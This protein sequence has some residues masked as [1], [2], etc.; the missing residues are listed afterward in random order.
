MYSSVLRNYY[1]ATPLFFLLDYYVHIRL[2]V[3][4][5]GA[6][7]Y[8]YYLYYLLCFVAGFVLFKHALLGALFSLL[9]SSI[10]LLLL[11]LTVFVPVVKLKQWQEQAI[12]YHFGVVELLHFMLV[13]AILLIGF[14]HNPLLRK[15]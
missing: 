15:R 14:Y 7:A 2:R 6:P 4:L 8:Y 3:A 11:L 10:N 5:P 9:E 12:T 13:G 1:L